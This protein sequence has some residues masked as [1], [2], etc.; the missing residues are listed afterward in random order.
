MN[1]LLVGLFL[2]LSHSCRRAVRETKSCMCEEKLSLVKDSQ[3][4]AKFKVVPKRNV[5]DG[6]YET[7]QIRVLDSVALQKKAWIKLKDT[8]IIKVDFSRSSVWL[9]EPEFSTRGSLKLVSWTDSAMTIQHDMRMHAREY[10]LG[11]KYKLKG[12]YTYKLESN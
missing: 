12:S 5:M 6:M 7:I 10:R 1:F 3:W 11:E 2:L 9:S 4:V 8:G